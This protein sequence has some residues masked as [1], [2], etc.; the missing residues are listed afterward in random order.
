MAE[1]ASVPAVPHR[2]NKYFLM[3]GSYERSGTLGFRCVQDAVQDD[4]QLPVDHSTIRDNGWW[5][6]EAGKGSC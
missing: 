5:W 4:A 3:D 2:H 6:C 1:E